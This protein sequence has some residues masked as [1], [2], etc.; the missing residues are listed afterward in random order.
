MKLLGVH[1][2]QKFSPNHIGNDDA[3]FSLTAQALEKQGNQIRICSE[4]EFLKLETVSE[5]Y[6][7]T[8]ARQKAVV[9]KLQAV[10]SDGTVVVNSG[11][12]I[13]NCF[14]INMHRALE[15]NGIPV[16]R[17]LV[18][19]T[20]SADGDPLERWTEQGFWIK[21]GDFHAI[22][23]EDVTFVRSR[24]EGREMLREYARRDIAEVL[25]SEHLAGDLVKF[26]GVRG[27]DFFFW[28]YPYE[29]NHHKYV[30]YEAIN[31]KSHHHAFDE[32][33]LQRVATAS[34]K[35]V[36]VDI[37]GGDA[38]VTKDGSFYI[39]DLNDWPSFAPCRQE[40]ADAIAALLYQKFTQP[41]L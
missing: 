30:E 28:F 22:H 36:G 3:I 5:P 27:T 32:T 33:E 1:R 40:A 19:P 2:N 8:M 11:F 7:F 38:I 20:S 34:A 29:H 26:Y 39:I 24:Q 41:V 35:A 13:E 15:E 18:I 12:G 23:R 25:I 31:G 14:R 10:E 16:P 37:Y 9:Q 21:R 17:S 6:I 4:D